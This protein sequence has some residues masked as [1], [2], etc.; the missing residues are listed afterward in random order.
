VALL[1][2]RNRAGSE[3][4]VHAKHM[5]VDD[6]WMTI[7]S[8]NIN[9]RGMTYDWEFD[10]GVIGRRLYKGGTAVVRNQRIEVCRRLLGLP[11]AYS[12]ALQ[13]V[14]AVFRMLK[15]IEAQDE[16]PTFRLHPLPPM[17]EKL[18][19]DHLKKVEG[20]A[21]FSG[22]VGFV[23]SMDVD[24]PNVNFL[25]CYLLDGDGRNPTGD[26]LRPIL[27]A[28]GI[29]NPL[30]AYA[31][32]SF[33]FGCMNQI[34]N[35]I[36]SG[37]T[38]FLE[39]SSTLTIKTDTGPVT[40]PPLRLFRL[41]LGLRSENNSDVVVIQDVSHPV[42]VPVSTEHTVKISASVTDSANQSLNCRG[43][44]IFDP[45]TLTIMPGCF[46]AATIEVHP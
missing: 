23:A 13:D 35:A 18:D 42:V 34:K 33:T 3:I 12:A 38:A 31:Q 19:P 28:A 5:I 22:G 46:H 30:D 10:A 29:R 40:R 14:Y 21:T 8:S 36:N 6:V 39:L 24:S 26:I 17:V 43:E 11:R 15:A 16:T 2:P 25:R 37:K 1:F 44:K 4:Y 20:D 45:G 7:G 32:I 27:D 9:Y 41:T